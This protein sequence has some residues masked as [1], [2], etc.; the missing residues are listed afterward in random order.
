MRSGVFNGLALMVSL[1][2]MGNIVFQ[3]PASGANFIFDLLRVRAEMSNSK[4]PLVSKVSGG[5]AVNDRHRKHPGYIP[6]AFARG[7][8]KILPA[9]RNSGAIQFPGFQMAKRGHGQQSVS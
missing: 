7:I 1:S 4:A 5:L 6:E 9:R 3:H 2:T 8:G